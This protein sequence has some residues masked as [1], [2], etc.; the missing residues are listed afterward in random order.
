MPLFVSIGILLA[1]MAGY[2]ASKLVDHF[3]DGIFGAANDMTPEEPKPEVKKIGRG[4][5]MAAA[6]AAAFAAG[7]LAADSTD[8]HLIVEGEPPVGNS[9]WQCEVIGP[10]LN[11]RTVCRPI[12]STPSVD[13]GPTVTPGEPCLG[14]CKDGWCCEKQGEAT[15]CMAALACEEAP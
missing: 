7:G 9:D 12:E 10:A 8:L 3:L 1:F 2:G 4:R 5:T 15:V 6:V 13:G 11:S 14:E